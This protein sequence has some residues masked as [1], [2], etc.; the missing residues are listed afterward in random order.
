MSLWQDLG[1]DQEGF[2]SLFDLRAAWRLQTLDQVVGHLG[3]CP[4]LVV[5][6]V[7]GDSGG[8]ASV[9]EDIAYR[10]TVSPLDET[11]GVTLGLERYRD[12]VT[13]LTKRPGNPFPAMIMVGRAG[14][15]DIRISLSTVSKVQGYFL[16]QASDDW[17][18]VDQRS[19][20]GT[21]VN[22]E[23]L[24]AGERRAVQDGDL[25]RFGKEFTVKLF[26]PRSAAGLLTGTGAATS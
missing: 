18:L 14:N 13:F 17:L 22:R 20:N 25:I 10:R 9:E 8:G 5:Q 4:A 3:G 12:R 6:N 21:F 26:M 2:V 24:G 15:C 19:T 11:G 7:A 1:L 23:R 16:K